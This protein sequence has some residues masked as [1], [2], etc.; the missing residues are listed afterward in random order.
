M[1]NISYDQAMYL[2]K[3]YNAVLIDVQLT[4]EYEK[5]HLT[6]SINI[7]IEEINKKI[8]KLILNKNQ[9]IIVY[10]LKGIRSEAAVDMLER[11]GYNEV[12]NIQGGIENLWRSMLASPF[13]VCI[14]SYLSLFM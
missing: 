11:L 3:I 5:N 7:P 12:Y 2:M 14:T 8:P 9:M 10:C 6:G 1:R 4:L 13:F